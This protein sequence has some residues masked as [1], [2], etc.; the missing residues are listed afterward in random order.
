MCFSEVFTPLYIWDMYQ[1]SPRIKELLLWKITKTKNKHSKQ[2]I[3]ISMTRPKGVISFTWF[4]TSL[5]SLTDQLGHKNSLQL[6]VTTRGS[7]WHS[8]SGRWRP[9]LFKQKASLVL[10]PLSQLLEHY[11]VQK[12]LWNRKHSMIN[13]GQNALS[14]L[15]VRH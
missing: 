12:I 8:L 1:H 2:L 9:K 15:N 5:H 10:T 4:V 14:V 7:S 3:L 11:S 6:C 13:A